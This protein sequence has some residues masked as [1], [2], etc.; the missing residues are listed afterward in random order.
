MSLGKLIDEVERGDIEDQ[1]LHAAFDVVY[2]ASVED[3]FKG[4]LDAAK[5][6]HDALLPGWDWSLFVE[7]A[8]VSKPFVCDGVTYSHVYYH[9]DVN[10]A[11]AWLICILRALEQEGRDGHV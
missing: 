1:T 8:E 9:E 2:W 6:L 3:A 10:A 4:S 5:S 11:R 7:S